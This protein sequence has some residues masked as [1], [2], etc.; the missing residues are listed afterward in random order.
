MNFLS[1]NTLRNAE[2]YPIIKDVN[3]SAMKIMAIHLG[4]MKFINGP[5]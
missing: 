2:Q 1:Q 4:I 3:V 5:G